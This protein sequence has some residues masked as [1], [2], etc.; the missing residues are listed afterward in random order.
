MTELRTH[1]LGDNCEPDGH[2]GDLRQ[3]YG[4]PDGPRDWRS[5][6]LFYALSNNP[7]EGVAIDSV[8]GILAEL[9]G[10]NDEIDWHWII[11]L[12]PDGDGVARYAYIDAWCDYS[13]WDCRSGIVD[14]TLG[15]SVANVM[16]KVPE[17]DGDRVIR[18]QLQAQLDGTQPFALEVGPR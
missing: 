2:R 3:Y 16:A 11:R 18:A 1:F 5:D 12:L 8:E 15:E 10:A 6:D 17:Q 9:P 7:I 13:G 4:D 14:C